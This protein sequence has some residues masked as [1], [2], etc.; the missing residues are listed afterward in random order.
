MFILFNILLRRFVKNEKWDNP[1][2]YPT[3]LCCQ[4]QNL[5]IMSETYVLALCN[6]PMVSAFHRLLQGGTLKVRTYT[7]LLCSGTYLKKY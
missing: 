5:F 3:S 4:T 6:H 2:D 7:F 1:H